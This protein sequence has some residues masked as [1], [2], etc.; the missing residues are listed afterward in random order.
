MEK[1]LRSL[2]YFVDVDLFLTDSAK[3]ADIVLPACSSCERGEFKV[4]GGGYAQYTEPVIPPLYQS[5]RDDDIILELARLLDIQD[6]PT[7]PG[8]RRL[9]PVYASKHPH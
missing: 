2:E 4:F 9:H 5:R 7:S 3:L 6:T 8:C 1:A